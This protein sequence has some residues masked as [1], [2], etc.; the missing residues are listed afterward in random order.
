MLPNF[1]VIGAMKAG[2]TSL[3]RYLGS[4]PNVFVSRTKELNFFTSEHNWEL[5]RAWYE[6]QFADAGGHAIAVGEASTNYAKHPEFSGV[7]GRIAALLPDVRL[8]YVVR[9][10]IDRMRSQYLHRI[11][12]GKERH[13]IETALLENPIYL[14]TSRYASQ[15][16]QYLEHFDRDRLLIVVSEKLRERRELTMSRVY[17]F[18]GVGPELANLAVEAEFYRTA[19]RR[20][21]RSGIRA[22]RERRGIAA[23][24]R[25]APRPLKRATVG[26]TTRSMDPDGATI[27]EDLRVRLVDRLRDDMRRFR[28]YMGDGFDS[29]GIE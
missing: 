26:L 9:D 21:Y 4:H 22:L 14:D 28:S 7:A 1:L 24:S 2:T 23:F 20:M 19:D 3:Y 8:L 13:A 6:R 12:R 10:P 27:S 17:E 16:G 18:L 29:W 15:I 5:G 11:G 25:L